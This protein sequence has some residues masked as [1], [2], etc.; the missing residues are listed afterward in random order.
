MILRRLD[1]AR[2]SFPRLDSQPI[3]FPTRNTTGPFVAPRP[4]ASPAKDADVRVCMGALVH[5]SPPRHVRLLGPGRRVNSDTPEESTLR[6]A[7]PR[8]GG[9]DAGKNAQLRCPTNTQKVMVQV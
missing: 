7:E 3:R 2:G 8:W 5:S 4:R 1:S 6:M 9:G